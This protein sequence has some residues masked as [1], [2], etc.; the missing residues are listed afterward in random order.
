MNSLKLPL[1]LLAAAVPWLLV[2]SQLP[3]EQLATVTIQVIDP[4]GM[5]VEGCRVDR[6][7]DRRNNNEASNFSGLRGTQIPYGTYAYTITRALPGGRE[8]REQGITSLF[9]SE[10][11]IVVIADSALL[12]AASED[13]A[14]P[15]GFVIQGKIEPNPSG[16]EAGPVWIR[17]TP[18]YGGVSLDLSVDGSGE[19]RILQLLAGRYL[20]TVIRGSQVL[21]IQ[22]VSFEAG[23]KFEDLVIRLPEEPPSVL[24]VRRK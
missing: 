2:I 18:V 11:L 24:I 12:K 3:A 17:L 23:P 21:Q 16:R 13:R 14:T 19:F 15:A 20:L 22:Q 6:F 1:R 9:S 8:G 7:V 10:N 4:L 5:P